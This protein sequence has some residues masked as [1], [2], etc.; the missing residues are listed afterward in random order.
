M[1]LG[2]SPLRGGP[3]LG[4]R[5]PRSPWSVAADAAA[6]L[7]FCVL[8]F[9]QTLDWFAAT[10][11]VRAATLLALALPLGIALADFVT[12]MIHWGGDTFFEEDT[13]VLGARWIQPFREHHR[14]PSAITRHGPLEVSGNN[15]L[16]LLVFLVAARFVGPDLHSAAG[17]LARAI[18][19]VLCAAIAISN[20]L[21]RW[22]HAPRS[23]HAVR[24]LQRHGLALSPEAHA[25]HHDGRHDR[26]FC[27]TTGWC[28]P[29]LDRVGFFPWLVRL[30]RWRSGPHDAR[31]S[32][33]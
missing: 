15:C 12:G 8:L 20:Q 26:A 14:D 5:E 9:A 3:K 21:H 31:V 13:P 17:A 25:R 30:A 27:V 19:L 7:G 2:R 22:A 18:F 33:S 32:G 16:L 29:M 10:G 4:R 11:G 6:V 24:W 23:T 1:V 28:N